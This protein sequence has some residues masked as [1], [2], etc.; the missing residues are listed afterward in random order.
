LKTKELQD[1]FSEC[2]SFWEENTFQ[3]L[4][5]RSPLLQVCFNLIGKLFESNKIVIFQFK[6]FFLAILLKFSLFRFNPVSSGTTC[7][8]REK[9]AE[10][11]ELTHTR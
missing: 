11:S 8:V 7:Y 5:V 6:Q 2:S 1:Q 10:K 3:I 4:V 9:E